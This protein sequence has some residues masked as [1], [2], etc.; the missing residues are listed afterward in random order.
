MEG[1]CL[2]ILDEIGELAE[3]P[4]TDPRNFAAIVALQGGFTI[5]NSPSIESL[6]VLEQC[7]Y[8]RC[9]KKKYKVVRIAS[10]KLFP[11]K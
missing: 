2:S 1:T 4:K 8:A 3:C 10:I 7:M 6:K 5:Y 9:T 11:R